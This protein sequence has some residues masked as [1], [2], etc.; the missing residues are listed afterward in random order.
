MSELPDPAD[1]F[2]PADVD[3][4]YHDGKNDIWYQCS[5]DRRRDQYVW[6]ILP[7]VDP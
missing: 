6:A 3:K 7:S 2:G 5:Y 4:L 1:C